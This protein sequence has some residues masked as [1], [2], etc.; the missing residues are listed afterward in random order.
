MSKKNQIVKKVHRD[1]R[2]ARGKLVNEIARDLL[3][4]P[5]WQRVKLAWRIVFRGKG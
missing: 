1:I 4:Q 2:R 3:T 5:F